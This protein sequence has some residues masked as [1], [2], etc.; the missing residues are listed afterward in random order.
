MAI[1]LSK[2][3][4]GLEIHLSPDFLM[5][6]KR[7]CKILIGNIKN[8]VVS[9]CRFIFFFNVCCYILDQNMILSFIRSLSIGVQVSDLPVWIT[10]SF[11]K[12][13][14]AK[15]KSVIQWFMV[16]N[17]VHIW[18]LSISGTELLNPLESLSCE[19]NKKRVFC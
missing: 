7:H 9:T 14:K 4:L 15:F 5:D 17:I 18:S 10:F 13:P 3:V 1:K 19:S 2:Q 8:A 12:V 16:R 11:L 6:S